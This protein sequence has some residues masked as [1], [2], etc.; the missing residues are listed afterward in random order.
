MAT[1]LYPP[2]CLLS[3]DGDA[4]AESGSAGLLAAGFFLL[5]GLCAFDDEA[6]APAAAVPASDMPKG[7]PKGNLIKGGHA[8]MQSS[9]AFIIRFLWH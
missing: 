4:A 5:F 6:L 7:G 3:R 1:D 2:G 9:N 8:Q